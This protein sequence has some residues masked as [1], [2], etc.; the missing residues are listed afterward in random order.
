MSKTF[1][2]LKSEAVDRAQRQ[3]YVAHLFD[4][5]APHY[6]R[7]NRWVS[8]FRDESWRKQTVALLGEQAAGTVLDLA[9]GT[10]DL[11][12]Q[13]AKTSQRRVHVFDI[14]FD[15]L[16]Q[17]KMKLRANGQV[18]RFAFEQGSGHLLPFRNEA[19]S[20]IVSGFAMRNVF[21]FLDEV[22][23]EMF[24][25]LEPGGKFAI[26]ELS[27]PQNRLLRAGFRLHMKTVVPLIGRLTTGKLD[28]FDYLY[29]TTMTFLS[30][31]EFKA[32]LEK[33]GFVEVS[34]KSYLL[35]GIAIHYGMKPG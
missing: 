14:S 27:K 7:F 15:M 19:F 34:W 8:L 12:R 30:P 23:S 22:L 11:A 32:M 24:R 1:G 26:L 29:Q 3:K 33:A 5:L 21:H 35:G 28:P 31:V 18:E 20:G 16:A 9:A 4:D 2:D 17:A 13:A 10:G 6:D 25:V